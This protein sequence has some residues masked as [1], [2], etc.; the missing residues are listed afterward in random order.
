MVITFLSYDEAA[1]ALTD[2]EVDMIC[3]V[4]VSETEDRYFILP[5]ST[6]DDTIHDISFEIRN[7]RLPSAYERWI[8]EMAM[9]QR[10][11]QPVAP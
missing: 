1:E 7:G 8:A 9:A 10:P 11:A 6:P 4:R 5:R 2:P 3:G